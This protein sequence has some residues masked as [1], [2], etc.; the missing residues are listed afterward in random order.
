MKSRKRTVL[1]GLTGALGALLPALPTPAQEAALTVTLE[2]VE[3]RGNTCFGTFRMDNGMGRDIGF[4]TLEIA[5]QRN[6]NLP[7]RLFSLA[8]MPSRTETIT[9]VT[10]PVLDSPC[11]VVSDLLVNRVD[12]CRDRGGAPLDCDTPL[13]ATSEAE[14]PL[15]K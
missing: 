6:D 2:A 7:G 15:T 8:L 12:V 3:S 14:V 10:L 1:V 4:L 5:V 13:E 11:S 9:R